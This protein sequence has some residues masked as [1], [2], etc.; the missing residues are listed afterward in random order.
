[1]RKAKIICTIGPASRTRARLHELLEA[2]MD[3]ARLNFSHG[4]HSEH[5]KV[6]RILREL[7]TRRKR[8]IA[9]LAD[10]AGPKIRTGRLRGGQPV[11]LR[12][13]QRLVLTS[14]DIEGTAE[15]IH[16]SYARLAREVEPG[17]R[18]LLADGLLELRVLSSRGREVV[19]RA[20]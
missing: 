17:G 19:C 16:V 9:I 11:Q 6:I 4:K 10:L 7:S 8:S 18:I 1:M 5:A 12:A 2:G 20:I 15:R 13:G 3:V 14:E